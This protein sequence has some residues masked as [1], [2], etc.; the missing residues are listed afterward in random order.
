VEQV[1]GNKADCSDDPSELLIRIEGVRNHRTKR[2]NV[3]PA[4]PANSKSAGSVH[5]SMPPPNRLGAGA[6]TGQGHHNVARAPPPPPPVRRE[7]LEGTPPRLG[8]Q[9]VL[10]ATG[11]A[12][13][14][15]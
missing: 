6:W 7:L 2:Y 14:D 8:W 3:S 15:Q 5:L 11:E 4:A 10:C 13:V 1:Y 12:A 9:P